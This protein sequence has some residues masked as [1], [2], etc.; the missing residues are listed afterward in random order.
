MCD[1]DI[2][3]LDV[4]DLDVA[5][6]EPFGI[7][8]SLALF[9]LP[10]GTMRA[11]GKAFG[12]TLNDVVMAVIDEALVRYLDERGELPA[13]RMVAA[14]PVS[15]RTAGDTRAGTDA[16]MIFVPLG[17]LDATPTARL[18][19]IIANTKAAKAEIRALSK[20][21]SKD[22]TILAISLSEGIGA[23]GL[24]NRMAPLA[25]LSIDGVSSKSAP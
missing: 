24:R 11:V 6:N 15:T 2:T 25:N 20:E 19:Q 22:Y 7:G 10:L 18:E 8:R 3:G 23:V 14:C 21:A 4:V 13:K 5:L 17:A 16:A 1:T 9:S 12:G